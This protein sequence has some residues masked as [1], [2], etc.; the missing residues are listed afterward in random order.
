MYMKTYSFK[1]GL[2]LFVILFLVTSVKAQFIEDGLRL[3]TP[4][5]GVGARSLGLG[6]A[7]TG[8]AN[9]YSAMYWNPAGLGQLGMNEFSIGLSNLSFSN[10]S[11]YY[12]ES[13]KTSN[14]TTALNAAGL[15]YV[16][17]TARGSLVFAMG[18]GRQNEFTSALSFK[19]FNPNS[20]IVQ[21]WAADGAQLPKD[22]TIAE[23]LQLAYADTLNNRFISPINDSLTQSGKI[24]EGGGINYWSFAGSI[25]AARNLYLGLTLN[26]ISG[27]YSYNRNYYEDDLNN[28]YPSTRYPFDVS[29]I[30]YTEN[31]QSD[32]AGFTMK[33]GLMYNPTPT[34]KIG[35]AIKTPSWITVTE[36]FTTFA[37]S[38]FKNNDHFDYPGGDVT[39]SYNEYNVHTPYV[40]SGG[41]SVQA[42]II[43][44]A[45]DL[46]YTDWTQLDFSISGPYS[47]EFDNYLMGLNQRVKDDLQQTLNARAGVE[48][49]IP[50]TDLSLRGGYA[51]LPSQYQ[52]DSAPNAKKYI[53]GGIGF[54][55]AGAIA[56]DL[57]YAYGYWETSHLVYEGK[58]KNNNYFSESTADQ[59][60]T[61]NFIATFAYRF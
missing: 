16:V 30:S 12:G 31:V 55:F 32:I 56:L 38:D 15:V 19:G 45:G 9:D 1:A 7:Y 27:S 49:A 2:S 20:S 58:D 46:E 21:A 36:A 51:Y 14:N 11:T 39:P 29:S 24:L 34:S 4:G 50:Q 40:F 10:T 52:Y 37:T 54:L 17:P 41:F 6:T 3:G 13:Q 25:E 8:V 23:Y 18:Y 47:S 28:V 59:V 48:V 57:G 44:F 5:L 53:T 43:I 42:G 26:F 22:Y 35:F 61:N 33:F 60:H